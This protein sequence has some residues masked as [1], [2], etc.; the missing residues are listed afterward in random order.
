MQYRNCPGSTNVIRNITNEDGLVISTEL[1]SDTY[2]VT[3]PQTIQELYSGGRFKFGKTMSSF[4]DIRSRQYTYTSHP[5]INHGKA[6]PVEAFRMLE[7]RVLE[8]KMFPVQG[9]VIDMITGGIGF[10]NHTV[11]SGISQGADWREDLLWLEPMTECVNTNLTLEFTLPHNDTFDQFNLRNVSLIDNGGF[12]NLIQEFPV[13]SM[14]DNQNNPQLRSRAYRSAWLV[15][16][17]SALTMNVTRPAP[18][19]FSYL[20]SELGKKFPLVSDSSQGSP[21]FIVMDK[22]FH[23]LVASSNVISTY[24]SSISNTTIIQGYIFIFCLYWFILCRW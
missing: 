12:V 24:N 11:P 3:I 14:S 8:E 17:L 9:L 10:R 1:V 16:A 23:S 13:L 22:L 15:N 2:D 18:N 6:Y 7:S 4:W 21:G 20:N 19:A 5:D